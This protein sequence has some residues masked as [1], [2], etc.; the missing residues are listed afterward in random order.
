MTILTVLVI[1]IFKSRWPFV[2]RFVA[3]GALLWF[4][5]LFFFPRVVTFCAGYTLVNMELMGQGYGTF[6]FCRVLIINGDGIGL[7][8]RDADDPSRHKR[9]RYYKIKPFLHFSSPFL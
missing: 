9:H 6:Q 8:N 4:W 1:D 7:R 5:R 2:V 3:L